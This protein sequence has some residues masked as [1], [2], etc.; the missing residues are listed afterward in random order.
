MLLLS[1][2][3]KVTELPL[4]HKESKEEVIISCVLLWVRTARIC[5]LH[6]RTVFTVIFINLS[7]G[8]QINV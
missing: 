6:T 2:N 1:L 8:L 5:S 4:K 7:K 3:Q